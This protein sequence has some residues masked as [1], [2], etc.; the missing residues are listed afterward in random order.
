MRKDIVV[1]IGIY[2]LLAI[3]ATYA[4]S[5]ILIV[6][7]L[8]TG[9]DAE[10]LI[11]AEEEASYGGRVIKHVA[12]PMIAGLGALVA[13]PVLYAVKIPDENK[14]RK[15]ITLMAVKIIVIII[16][17]VILTYVAACAYC[18]FAV[19]GWNNVQSCSVEI[20]WIPPATKASCVCK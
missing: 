1:I 10:P 14:R 8:H 20:Q 17:G 7:S 6:I 9:L 2:A 13:S 4:V 19:C 3:L 16:I 12:S 5:F 18:T 15:Y 11:V